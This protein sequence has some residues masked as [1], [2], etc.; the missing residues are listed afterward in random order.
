MIKKRLSIGRMASYFLLIFL[1]CIFVVP[2]LWMLT[3]SLKTSANVFKVPAQWFPNPIQW[4]NYVDI[5][6]RMDFLQYFLNT[7]ILSVIPVFGQL[8]S[9][10]M[11][12]YSIAKVP[13][14]GGKFIFPIIL[15]TMMVPWQVTMI[16]LYTTWSK[17]GFV[18]TYV[19][20]LLPTFFG[21]AYY[22]FLM[23]QFIRGLPNS[24]V[25]AARIDG[26]GEFRILYSIIYPLCRPVLTTI[27]LLVFIAHW[28]DLNGPL[29]Y[30][31]DSN[32]YTLSLGLQI[33][34]VDMSKEFHLLMA[35]ATLFTVPLIITFFVCQKQFIGGIAT[36]G[37]K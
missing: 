32:K 27:A 17:L 31:F 29:I 21:G 14:N 23:R 37:F 15:A 13:W 30:L 19:P 3:T 33:F 24:L 16:P 1:C 4:S 34:M 20:L 36:T 9:T 25:E 28:N 18:N 2:F 26:A 22:I 8:F 35:A 7:V 10:P 5:F 6:K 11:V 12:A